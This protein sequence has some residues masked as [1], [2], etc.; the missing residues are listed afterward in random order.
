MFDASGA[1]AGGAAGGA[2]VLASLVPFP[3]WG[4]P[5]SQA[6]DIGCRNYVDPIGP[7]CWL[8]RPGISLRCFVGWHKFL[9]TADCTEGCFASNFE[10][11]YFPMIPWFME[12]PEK[13]GQQLENHFPWPTT[14]PRLQLFYWIPWMLSKAKSRWVAPSW[15]GRCFTRFGDH[16]G[17]TL[18]V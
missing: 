18:E 9:W 14:H 3:G 2:A 6:V 1:T 11:W 16:R 13:S 5:Q 17:S 10:M 4:Y 7:S 15:D 8:H 12:T